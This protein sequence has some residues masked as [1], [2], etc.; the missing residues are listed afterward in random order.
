MSV[1]LLVVEDKERT[2]QQLLAQLHPLKFSVTVAKDGLDGLSKAKAETFELI[3][4]DHKMPLM[5]GLTLVKNLRSLPCY[6]DTPILL[7]TTQDLAEVE[8]VAL[9]AGANQC[10]GKPLHDEDLRHVLRSYVQRS[11]A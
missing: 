9:K 6:R 3:I 7:M 1:S 8:P 10:L 11:V 2:R 4:T 5:D